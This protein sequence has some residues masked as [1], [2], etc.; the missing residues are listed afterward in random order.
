VVLGFARWSENKKAPNRSYE[1]AVLHY[2]NAVIQW[3]NIILH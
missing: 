2:E 3:A 1:N